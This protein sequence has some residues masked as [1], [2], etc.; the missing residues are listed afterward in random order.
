MGSR[1]DLIARLRRHFESRSTAGL[2]SVYLFGSAAEGREHRESDVDIGLLLDPSGR[3]T[4]RERFAIRIETVADL[5]PAVGR[6][7]DVVVLNDAPPL[8]ARRIVTRGLRVL[9]RDGERD[10][11]F[12]R[13]IQLLAADLVPFLRRMRAIKLDAL[14]R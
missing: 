4:E 6:E 7:V 11:A 1:E 13:D 2:V 14:A 12:R 9:C 5:G 10:H 3:P 8:L